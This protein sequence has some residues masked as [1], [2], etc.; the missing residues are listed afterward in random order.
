MRLLY[1]GFR[2]QVPGSGFGGFGSRFRVR[3]MVLGSRF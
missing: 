1:P 3:F 2:V